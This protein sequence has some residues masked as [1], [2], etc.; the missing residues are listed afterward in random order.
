MTTNRAMHTGHYAFM[1]YILLGSINITNCLQTSTTLVWLML[2]VVII[3]KAW[4]VQLL[5][6]D[7]L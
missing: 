5:V 3:I 1:L 6:K 2:K 4:P 7:Q